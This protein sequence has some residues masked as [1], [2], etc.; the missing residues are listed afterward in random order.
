MIENL[1]LVKL[2]NIPGLYTVY[3][4]NAVEIFERVL[5]SSVW[6]FSKISMKS[7]FIRYKYLQHLIFKSIV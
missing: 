7:D 5:S 2:W 3:F 1:F 4:S 6:T